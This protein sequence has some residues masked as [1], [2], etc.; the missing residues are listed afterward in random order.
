V[1]GYK[2]VE[3]DARGNIVLAKEY[4]ESTDP[5]RIVTYTYDEKYNPGL[6][7]PEATILPTDFNNILTTTYKDKDGNL[8]G[9]NTTPP[10]SYNATGYPLSDLGSQYT[11][12]CE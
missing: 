8:I 2:E 11:Y 12:S 10:R 9:N 3:T 6:L 4:Q 5:I 7:K 1:K